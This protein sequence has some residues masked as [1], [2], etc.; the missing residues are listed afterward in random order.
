MADNDQV[1]Q[2]LKAINK[3]LGEMATKSDLA[4]TDTA[5]EAVRAGLED[6]Q[7][8]QKEQATKKDVETA[9]NTAKTELKKELDKK[10]DK[11]DI[12]KLGVKIEKVTE[13]QETRLRELEAD[14]GIHNRGK[15]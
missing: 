11:A 3:R 9:V 8:N 14:H 6:V 15:N 10:A 4:R 2:E 13:N 1:L 5:L 12:M 7:A